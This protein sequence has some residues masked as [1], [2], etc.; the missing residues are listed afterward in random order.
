M[1]SIDKDEYF[2]QG[3]FEGYMAAIDMFENILEDMTKE[4]LGSKNLRKTIQKMIQKARD[5]ANR[6]FRSII[7][8]EKHEE[9]RILN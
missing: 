4:N 7:M 1:R 3:W 9:E 8:I 6:S 5:I 2:D